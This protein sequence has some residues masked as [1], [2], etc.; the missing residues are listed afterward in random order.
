[1]LFLIPSVLENKNKYSKN[2]RIS[3]KT[4]ALICRYLKLIIYMQKLEL[5]IRTGM[6]N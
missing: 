2:K 4:K 5:K 1:M 3:Y 6:R